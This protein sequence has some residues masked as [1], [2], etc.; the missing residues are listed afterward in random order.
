[1]DAVYL[2]EI[3]LVAVGREVDP[4]DMRRYWN[5]KEL[6]TWTRSSRS[7]RRFESGQETHCG[8]RWRTAIAVLVEDYGTRRV[9]ASARSLDARPR[10]RATEH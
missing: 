5:V 3:W 4:E 10:A 1:M 7:R 8:A 6:P 9:I 2:V